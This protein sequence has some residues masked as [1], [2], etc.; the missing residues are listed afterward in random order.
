LWFTWLETSLFD[1]RFASDSFFDRICKAFSFGI[2]TGFAMVGVLYDTTNVEHNAKAFQ[3]MSLILMASRLILL[4]QYGVILLY[5]R[6]Y[7][8]TRIPLLATMVTLLIAAAVFLGTYWGFNV[9]DSTDHSGE[10]VTSLAHPDTYLAWYV[11]AVLEAT[12]VLAISC[13][14]R[15]VS[16]KR[17]HLVERIGLLTLIMMGEGILSITQSVSQILW[18]AR[19]VKGSDIG[20]ITSCVLLIV[21]LFPCKV[22]CDC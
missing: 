10:E 19:V 5:V 7:H 14:W 18:N 6:Q 2:M 17:T 15:V 11:V 8:H 4:V 3:A 12:S 21:S 20:V 13:T 22:I 9:A 16:F 1:V